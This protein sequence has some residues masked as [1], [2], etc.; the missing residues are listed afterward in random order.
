MP[1]LDPHQKWVDSPGV[2]DAAWDSIINRLLHE[3]KYLTES[4][5]KEKQKKTEAGTS[6]AGNEATGID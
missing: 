1:E 5:A 4:C 3:F 2:D 6:S